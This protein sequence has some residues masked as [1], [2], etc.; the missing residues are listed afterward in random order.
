MNRTG[1][2]RGPSDGRTY[3]TRV[4]WRAA[5]PLR[6]RSCVRRAAACDTSLDIGRAS[7][8]SAARGPR[9]AVGLAGGP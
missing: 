3:A 2:G 4:Q 6:A 1:G 9:A 7:L 8:E 5:A